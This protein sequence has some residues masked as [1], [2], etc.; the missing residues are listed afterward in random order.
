MEAAILESATD[1]FVVTL[2]SLLSQWAFA[3]LAGC[4]GFGILSIALRAIPPAFRDNR[5]FWLAELLI[6]PLAVTYLA[7][8]AIAFFDLRETNIWYNRVHEIKGVLQALIF[9]HLANRALTLFV[10]QGPL[11][12]YT[13]ALPGILRNLLTFFVY[14]A[15][16]YAILAYVFEQ[17]VTGLLV[18]SG[19]ALGV[20]GLAFQS[21]LTDI[22]SGI[23]LAIERPFAVGDWIESDEGTCG[24]VEAIDWRATTLRTLSNTTHVIPNNKIANTAIHNLS[25]PGPTYCLKVYISVS[26]DLP[27]WKV[28]R[29]LL[30]A[31]IA[32]PAVAETPAPIVRIADGEHRPIRYLALL[33]CADYG[34]HPLARESFLQNAWRLLDEAGAEIAADTQQVELKRSSELNFKDPGEV[35]S[36][37]GVELFNPLNGCEKQ[38]LVDAGT[39]HELP[40][41]EPIVRYNEEG[42]SFFVVLSGMVRVF[43]PAGDQDGAE[44]ELARLCAG[45]YFGEMSLLTGE[46]RSASVSAHTKARVLEI[47]KS[48]MAPILLQRPSLAEDLARIMAERKLSTETAIGDGDGKSFAD[49]LSES[50][51]ELVHRI[52]KFFKE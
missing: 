10:W 16:V 18:S 50:T 6:L 19:I 43:R 24:K 17:P 12:R 30:E 9:A 47:P 51:R 40:E 7:A 45:S 31:A 14:L 23:S 8:V 29:L 46:R 28:S 1:N 5:L 32:A 49:R 2:T 13:H 39:V 21:T 52:Q 20:L 44:V 22:I 26:A 27:P 3:L 41:A 15:A 11:R 34:D 33:H 38:S 37:D 36:I 4:L 35:V 48:A 42:Q 25:R